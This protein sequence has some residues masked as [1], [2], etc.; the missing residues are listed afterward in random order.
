MS[1]ARRTLLSLLALPALSPLAALAQDG[2]PRKPVKIIVNFAAGGPLDVMAR[3]LGEQLSG[4]VGQ[5][6]VVEN[7]TG[8]NGNLGVQS[9]LRAD[10]D[11][12]TLLFTAE[13]AITV[14]PLLY[15]SL[16]YDPLADMA[17][18]RLVGAFEQVLTVPAASG[19]RTVDELVAKAK[20]SQLSYASAGNGSPGHLAFVAFA[21]RAGI[22]ATHVPY[23]GNAPAVN[24]LLAG[25]VDAAYVVIG[26]VR[27]HLQSGKLRALAVSGKERSPEMPDVPTLE[28]AGFPGFNL[29]YGYVI[30]VPKDTSRDIQDYWQKHLGQALGAPA[31]VDRYRQLDTRMI[32]ADGAA[33]RT[34]LAQASGRWKTALADGAVKVE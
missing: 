8:A 10:P 24:D 33:A 20:Q 12:H 4:R 30:T 9:L 15:R 5:P 32:N 17:P 7:I 6:V 2:F 16:G 1:I 18:V 19:I 34:W 28:Q 11:G 22:R 13:T 25:H 26:G 3:V 21:Q 23:R 27:P 29:S 14:S 31:L